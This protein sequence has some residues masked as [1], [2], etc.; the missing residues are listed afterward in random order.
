MLKNLWTKNGC[1]YFNVFLKKKKNKNK[2][3]N[4]QS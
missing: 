1:Y 2:N 3:K 4:Q